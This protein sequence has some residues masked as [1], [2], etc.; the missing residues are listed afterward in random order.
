MA[1]LRCE[2][3]ALAEYPMLTCPGCGGFRCH[4]E[5]RKPQVRNGHRARVIACDECKAEY[6]E[7]GDVRAYDDLEEARLSYLSPHYDWYKRKV[8]PRHG[9]PVH[10][11]EEDIP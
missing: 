6:C 2:A 5:F 1:V 8:T 3:Y 9:V 11:H 4:T 10:L 7:N